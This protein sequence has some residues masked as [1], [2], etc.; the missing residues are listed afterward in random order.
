MHA[1]RTELLLRYQTALGRVHGTAVTRAALATLTGPHALVALGKAAGAMAAGARAVPTLELVTTFTAA[2]HGYGDADYH[3]GHPV[4][5]AASLA[6][7]AAFMDWL[8]ALPPRLPLIALVSGGASACIEA[9]RDG[10]TLDA[11]AA[12][13]RALL[14]SGAGI[15]EINAE[16]A[17]FSALKR[18]G[19]RALAGDREIVLWVLSDVPGDDPALVGSGPFAGGAARRL[20]TNA[21]A[22][23]AV[24]ADHPAQALAGDAAVQGRA[25]AEFLRAAAPGI[26]VWGGETTVALPPAPGRGGRC[27]HLA[28]AAAI[29]LDGCGGI[30]LLAAGTDG[31]DGDSGDAGALVDGGT[32]ARIRAEGLDP[33][34]ALAHADSNAAL[35]AAGDL[36]HTGPTG[37]N[38]MDLVI[39]VRRSHT[40]HL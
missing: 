9:L 17:R 16:R 19:A 15:A 1:A 32:A 2:P 22:V 25:I 23:A 33:A 14:A 8:R 7:G 29:A 20:S 30:T 24:G 31:I 18:G 35:A 39:A 11:L 3:G 36:V 21:E 26:W 5:D 34:V 12:R 4:P 28:L 13:T 38:V 40:A 27:Q 10:A 37:T 6:A